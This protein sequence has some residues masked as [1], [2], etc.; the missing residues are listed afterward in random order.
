MIDIPWIRASFQNV[1]EAPRKPEAQWY[2]NDHC[3]L[4]DPSDRIHWFGIINPYP[5]DGNL[6]GPGSHRHIGHAVA[7]HPFGPWTLRDHAF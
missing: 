6:Y 3:I 1:L 7:E 4:V 2:I 5:V